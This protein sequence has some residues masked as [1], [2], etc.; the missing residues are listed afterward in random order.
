MLTPSSRHSGQKSRSYILLLSLALYLESFLSPV[1]RAFKRNLQSIPATSYVIS[2]LEESFST[3]LSTGLSDS[4]LVS[5]SPCS[6]Q[7]PVFVTHESGHLMTVLT[8]ATPPIS[9]GG[10]KPPQQPQTPAGLRPPLV[11]LS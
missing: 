5:F 3:G 11:G 7:Q 1:G 8:A 4:V 6:A 9:L 2:P 10:T